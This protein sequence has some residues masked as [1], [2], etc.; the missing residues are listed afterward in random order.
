MNTS[1][2][3]FYPVVRDLADVEYGCYCG[4]ED[5]SDVHHP[6]QSMYGSRTLHQSH[7]PLFAPYLGEL[8]DDTKDT[9]VASAHSK[10]QQNNGTRS[11]KG[12]EDSFAP[13]LWELLDGAKDIRGASAHSKRQQ[14]DGTRSIKSDESTTVDCSDSIALET[15]LVEEKEYVKFHDAYVI[16][17]QVRGLPKISDNNNI[18]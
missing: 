9:Q 1:S 17:R 14:N 13:Y 6:R 18:H 11:R 16:T 12:D 7:S 5:E 15:G 8:L 10:R 2:Q 3:S 4:V